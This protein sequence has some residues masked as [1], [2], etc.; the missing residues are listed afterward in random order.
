MTLHTELDGTLSRQRSTLSFGEFLLLA[1][2]LVLVAVV[3]RQFEIESSAFLR[4][5]LLAFVGFAVHAVL[6]LRYRLPFFV[7]LSFTGI[8][9]ILGLGSG[10]WLVGIGLLLILTCHLPLSLSVRVGVLVLIAIGLAFL[11]LQ[12]LRAP[13]PQAIWPILGSMFMFRLMVYLYDISHEPAPVSAWRTLAYFFLLPNVCFPLFP[14][15]DYKTFRR[16]Y[17]GAAAFHTY[18]V[19]VD[20]ITRGIIHL[21]LYRFV[22]Y[23][24]ALAPSEVAHSKDLVRYMVATFLLYLRVSGQF[25]IIV[26][27]LHLFGFNLPE[28][29]HHYLFASSFTDFWR[30]INIYWKDFMMKMFFYPSYFRLKKLG[31]TT[32]LIVSTVVV[33]VVTWVLHSYQWF[34]LRGNF[35]ITKMDIVFWSVLGGLVLVN[36]LYEVKHG[37][38]RSLGK[39]EWRLGTLAPR[40]LRTI[41][42]FAIITLI[43]SVW[44]GNSLREWAGMWH[45]AGTT[46]RSSAV[47]MSFSLVGTMV[48]GE[49][50]LRGAAESR[51][52]NINHR[53]VPAIRRST[54][55]TMLSLL[56]L[57]LI[58]IPAFYS[59]LN[60][61]AANFIL[62]LRSAHLS[63]IDAALMERGYYEELLHVDRFNSQLWE[64]YA[65]RPSD[66]LDVQATGLDRFTGDFLQRELRPSSVSI[67]RYGTVSTNRWGMRDQDYSQQPAPNTYRAALLGSSV[68]FG[69]GVND[70]ETFEDVLER[71]LNQDEA[72]RSGRRYEILNFAV[73]GYS[74][75]QQLRVLDKALAFDPDTV[76]YVAAGHEG[77]GALI[78]LAEVV[79]KRI[80]VPYAHLQEIVQR[81]GIRP[82]TPEASAIR[83][84]GP[85]QHEIVLWAYQ[86]IVQRCK[87]QGVLP[88]WTFVPWLGT[89]AGETEVI[90][91]AKEAGFVV[92]D[93]GNVY[94][95]QDVKKLRI[96]EWDGHPNAAGHALIAARLYEV[97]R[98]K[99]GL[100]SYRRPNRAQAISTPAHHLS[101]NEVRVTDAQGKQR[102]D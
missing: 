25:H 79:R 22:Y 47:W 2:Q 72:S 59:R 10:L 27:I 99:D 83:Q 81:A 64:V 89:Y 86:Q 69:S 63:R 20:W 37:R 3:I 24:M 58:G 76:W 19:G 8:W 49:A 26:G 56:M 93:L 97:L 90:P 4:I 67:T 61:T 30:R 65:K 75:L 87:Q 80:P 14:V 21:I 48:V 82:D 44:S 40:A 36:S 92:L 43:W 51:R 33:F 100:L 70:G 45:F 11:R 18:Q 50:A 34:W 6:P 94:Q 73:P 13:W 42:T 1:G 31:N 54:V 15:V 96:A 12:W 74:A 16:G 41:G 23:Y 101:P 85:F 88:I 7:L 55:V 98:A 77:S 32:A 35:P 17:Y 9:L 84:L 53:R 28:T 46:L 66:W 5:A 57:T 39:S 60:A 38:K 68:A 102:P 29:N 78:Y 52:S 62:S 95:G 91:I 71:R